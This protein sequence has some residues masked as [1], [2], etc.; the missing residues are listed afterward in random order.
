MGITK[1]FDLGEGTE[2]SGAIV[3]LI[4]LE[5]E[6]ETEIAFSEDLP[7]FGEE[8][9]LDRLQDEIGQQGEHR[10]QDHPEPERTHVKERGELFVLRG[11]EGRELGF[12]RKDGE[13][14][15]ERAPQTEVNDPRPIL[16]LEGRLEEDHDDG[17]RQDGIAQR[18]QPGDMAVGTEDVIL[19]DG[20]GAEGQDQGVVDGGD[21]PHAEGFE[22]KDGVGLGARV[23]ARV[24]I[25]EWLGT[26]ALEDAD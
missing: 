2:I 6:T 15:D 24:A 12:D 18:G 4:I 1:G 14:N 22:R 13:I 16:D 21:H 26:V 7:I 8:D 5:I 23:Q 17:G 25:Q 3:D 10:N 11:D 19:P 20:D 9:F